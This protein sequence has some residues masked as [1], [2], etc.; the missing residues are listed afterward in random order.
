MAIT[1]ITDVVTPEIYLAYMAEEFP[2]QNALVR[3]GVFTTPPPNVVAQLNAGGDTIQS[4]YWDYI[5]RGEPQIPSDVDTTDITPLKVTADKM[6]M[7]KQYWV[8]AWSSMDLAGILAT[9][10][11]KDPKAHL[12]RSLGT[13]WAGAEQTMLFKTLEGVKADNDANDSDDMF[14]SVYNDVASPTASNKFSRSAFDRALNTMG[15]ALGGVNLIGV[16]SSVYLSMKDND[17]IDFIQDSKLEKEIPMYKGC[18][19]IVDDQATV[20]TGTNSDKYTTY[21]LGPGSIA[22]ARASMDPDRVIE[23]WREPLSGNGGGQTTSVV[24]ED[25]I[26]HPMGMDWTEASVA[27]VG[28]TGTELATA[29]NWDRKYDR[30]NVKIAFLDTNAA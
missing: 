22:F 27:G 30:K 16:H 26:L 12:L 3:S 5:P 21:L 14:Y 24:R 13:Y 20:T 9:G 10:N 19:V 8:Q 7:R 17:D 4:P 28:P 1:K 23:D 29:T 6:R 15:D 11:A 25:C 18:Q 2:E